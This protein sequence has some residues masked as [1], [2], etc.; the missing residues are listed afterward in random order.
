MASRLLQRQDGRSA[1]TPALNPVASWSV[2]REGNRVRV[3]PR[4]PE[5]ASK[6]ATATAHDSIVIVGAGPAGFV[7]AMTLRREGFAGRVTLVGAE[8]TPP[9]DRPNLSKDYLAGK[10]PEEWLPLRPP[11]FFAEQRIELVTGVAVGELDVA[12]RCA[13]LADGRSIP[14]G[15]LLLATGSEPVPLEVPGASLPH[16]RYLRT[17]AD[18][19]AIIGRAESSRRAVVIGSSFIGLEAAA[20]LR[21]RGLDVHVVSRDARPLER[22]LGPEVGDLIRE[23]HESQGV[24]FHLGESPASIDARTVILSGGASLPADLVVVGIGVRPSTG[25]AERAGLAVDR[26]IVVDRYLETSANGI[27]AAGDAARYPDPRGGGRLRIEHWV[28]AERQGQTAARNL[29]GRREPF[30]AVP[31]FWS[32]HYD[33]SLNYVGHAE[34][35]DSTELDGSIARRE[36]RLTYKRAGR[37]LAVL[38]LSRDRDSLEAEAAMER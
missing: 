37:V 30:D 11:E 32:Q 17:L 3:G 31:F 35:W 27:F 15:A 6:P 21:Q 26:G 12:K 20:A 1:P 5:P 25:L 33:L 2:I 14:Y 4:R 18:S 24:V 29:M 9:V 16:V 13:V 23:L 7:A 8:A 19:R 34:H 22:V 10:A 38:T 36:F 28:V